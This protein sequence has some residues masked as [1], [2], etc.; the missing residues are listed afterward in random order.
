MIKNIIKTLSVTVLVTTIFIACG[1][2]QIETEKKLK[3]L[4]VNKMEFLLQNGLVIHIQKTQLLLLVLLKLMLGMI[5]LY[6]EVKQWQ[7][8]EML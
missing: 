8:E 2:K 1:S 7:M 5:N 3:Y 4:S 6:K